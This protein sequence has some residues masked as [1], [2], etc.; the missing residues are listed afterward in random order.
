VRLAPHRAGFMFPTDTFVPWWHAAH[1]RNISNSEIAV[2]RNGSVGTTAL[3][4][5]DNPQFNV[6]NT[7]QRPR[8]YEVGLR[9][10][11]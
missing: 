1:G 2:S 9:L 4:S 7:Y 5:P 8:H 11:F 6:N 3:S 10:E